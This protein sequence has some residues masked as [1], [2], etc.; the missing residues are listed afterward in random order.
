MKHYY[1]IR[2]VDDEIYVEADVAAIP[3][4]QVGQ[5]IEVHHGE[6]TSKMRIGQI[7]WSLY[8]PGT[9][10]GHDPELCATV[11]VEKIPCPPP[12]LPSD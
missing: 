10:V 3:P 1:L 2:S 4:F 7:D 6:K 5:E 11:L 12:P 8:T 9:G